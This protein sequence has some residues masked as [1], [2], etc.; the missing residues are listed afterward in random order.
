MFMITDDPVA[1][2]ERYFAER[3]E[4]LTVLPICSCCGERIQEDELYD[5]DGDL[6]CEE[7]LPVYL[8]DN[9]KKPT[10][11]YIEERYL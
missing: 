7:C 2:A 4:A 6:V 5:F 11:A 1:D 10:T 9:Y 3:D 8:A